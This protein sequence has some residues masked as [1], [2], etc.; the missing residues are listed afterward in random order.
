MTSRKQFIRAG[1]VAATLAVELPA[2][3]VSRVFAAPAG[4]PPLPLLG[5][6][7][8]HF[9][10]PVPTFSRSRVTGVDLTVTMRE[11][12]QQILP[13]SLYARLPA[14]HR[15]GT[16]LWGYAIGPR[17][18]R[19]PGYTIEARHGVPMTVRY[20][21]NLPRAADHSQLARLLTV[22]QTIH[23][24]DPDH[25]MGSRRA[26]GGAIPAVVHLH[27]GQV[28]STS[29][30]AP[31]AWYTA[32][33]RHGPAYGTE[34]P[35][36]AN[37][38][39][40]RYP[41]G[42]PATTLWLHDHALGLTRLNVFA[43]LAAFYLLRD[44]YDT[45]RVDNPLHLPAGAYEVELLLQDRQFDIQGQLLFPNGTPA[46]NPTGLNGPPPNPG[47]H[48]FWIP[49]FFGDVMVVNGKSWPYMD[50]EPRRYRLRI[51]NGCNARFLQLHLAEGSAQRPGPALWQ[52]GTDGGLLNRPVQLLDS[53][54]SNARQF[55]GAGRAR[56]PDRGFRRL[57][58]EDA[59][60]PQHGTSAVPRWRLP[61]SPHHGPGYAV[62]RH[63]APHR[64][65]WDLRPSRRHA[66]T[67]PSRHSGSDRPAGKP[68]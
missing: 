7:V 21:N 22:D 61:R 30:G 24:A 16:F 48:P 45:G 8:P 38:A 2:Q 65:R 15:A 11:F 33:G 41:N 43:G 49:E 25:Q 60:P 37:A 67:W 52:I 56:G 4:T 47:I 46:N 20:V 68:G 18:A 34:A 6:A 42:Q 9:V 26:Y 35:T 39:V 17:A 64:A 12:Q 58:R 29:D 28:P 1:A 13:S 55:P 51:V 10:E 53:H 66:A 62:S 14:P 40:F 23:W 50:V 19:Y 5:S 31:E 63:A 59:P 32:D 27:G 57:G 36:S 3:A 44:D 54:G